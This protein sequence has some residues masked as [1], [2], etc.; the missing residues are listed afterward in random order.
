MLCYSHEMGAVTI[1]LPCMIDKIG[2]MTHDLVPSLE[3]SCSW[4]QSGPR[5]IVL[6]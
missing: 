4:F 1:G 5:I 6:V 2:L 3:E